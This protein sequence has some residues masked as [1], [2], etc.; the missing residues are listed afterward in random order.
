S[1]EGT[2]QV[3][4]EFAFFRSVHCLS[5]VDPC[6]IRGTGVGCLL[7]AGTSITGSPRTAVQRILSPFPSV[8]LPGAAHK[9]Q[10]RFEPFIEADG[11]FVRLS[12]VSCRPFDYGFG[13]RPQPPAISDRMCLQPF[14]FRHPAPQFA[15]G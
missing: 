11:F 14:G 5:P 10:T 13:T 15:G 9:R 8:R 7:P 2:V 3:R 12:P 4:D 6:P 1:L